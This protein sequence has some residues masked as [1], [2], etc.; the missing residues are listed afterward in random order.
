MRLLVPPERSIRAV[1]ARP[2]CRPLASSNQSN[3]EAGCA[4]AGWVTRVRVRS[5]HARS[6]VRVQSRPRDPRRGLLGDAPRGGVR[7]TRL[8]PARRGS[9][10]PRSTTP[11]MPTGRSFSAPRKGSKLLGLT[12][13]DDVAFEIDTFGEHEARSVIVR[14]RAR[15]ARR[16]RGRRH[17]SGYRCAPG[18]TPRSS[19]SSP[20][21]SIASP[22]AASG[23]PAP[24]CTCARSTTEPGPPSLRRAPGPTPPP[25]STVSR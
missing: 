2:P 19:T 21:R 11:S 17:R 24:G 9:T 8:P 20:S 18:S 4:G 22:A 1:S 14:G 10:S 13:N 12:I 6:H 5:S 23:S 25:P 16:R 7:P 15:Q 3:Q